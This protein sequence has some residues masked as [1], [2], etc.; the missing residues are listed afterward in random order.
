[1]RSAERMQGLHTV[2]PRTQC[3]RKARDVVELHV[4]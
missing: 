4:R 3:V 1:M 2:I